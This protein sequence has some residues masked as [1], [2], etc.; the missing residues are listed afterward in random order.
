MIFIFYA[1]LGGTVL[2][3]A[4]MQMQF[5]LVKVRTDKYLTKARIYNNNV[6]KYGE[7]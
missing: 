7:K 1:M 5:S 2:F 3:L 4:Y 6:K